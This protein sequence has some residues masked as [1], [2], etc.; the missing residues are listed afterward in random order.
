VA[1]IAR[2]LPQVDALFLAKVRGLEKTAERDPVRA[3]QALISS[4]D[5]PIPLHPV[6]GVL[7]AEI[8]VKAPL[9]LVMGSVPEC[10]VAGAR[11]GTFRRR[12]RLARVLS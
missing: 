5:T 3:R 12:V 10:V 4:I 9:P 7:E 8:G 11:F 6:G 2:L 1:P